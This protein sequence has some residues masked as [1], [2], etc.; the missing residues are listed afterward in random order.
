V[1]F[2]EG[3]MDMPSGEIVFFEGFLFYISFGGG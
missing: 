3:A 1:D 2:P